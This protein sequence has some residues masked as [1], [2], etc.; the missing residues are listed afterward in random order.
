MFK[1]DFSRICGLVYGET[2]GLLYYG[3]WQK[4]NKSGTTQQFLRYKC[5]SEPLCMVWKYIQCCPK[6]TE[7]TIQRFDFAQKGR[8]Y[9]VPNSFIKWTAQYAYHSRSSKHY[10][11][12]TQPT[13]NGSD[14]FETM[15]RCSQQGYFELMSVYHSART[16]GITGTPFRFF[17]CFYV[18]RSFSRKLWGLE[19]WNLGHAYILKS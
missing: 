12:D 1:E 2:R 17:V 10:K 5:L 18:F 9:S 11:T 4:H 3:K 8:N 14:T 6:L 19:P 15:K 16:G 13:F 7:Y